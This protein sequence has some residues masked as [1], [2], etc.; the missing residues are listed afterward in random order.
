VQLIMPLHCFQ[1]EH[2]PLVCT[3]NVIDMQQPVLPWSTSE[4]EY[5]KHQVSMTLSSSTGHL[6]LGSTDMFLARTPVCRLPVSS[7]ET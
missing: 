6:K 5:G 4:L 1:L 2:F 7:A 3:D